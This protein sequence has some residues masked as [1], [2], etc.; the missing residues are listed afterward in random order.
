MLKMD[1]VDEVSSPI[2][3]DSTPLPI[4]VGDIV[5]PCAQPTPTVLLA[6][7]AKT[8]GQPWF[9]SQ[10]AAITGTDRDALDEPLTQLRIAGLIRIETW[11]RGVGQ[12]YVLTP[13]GEKAFA[14]GTG[15]PTNEKPPEPL[16]SGSLP[17]IP[18][19]P[20][21]MLAEQSYAMPE[22]Q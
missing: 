2:S 21:V 6:W 13:P 14:T 16:S 12:G 20:T 19:D 5:L 7:I 17:A 9:P 8:S 4:Q 3:S 11:V 15:I 18:D 22:E 1:T 10:H